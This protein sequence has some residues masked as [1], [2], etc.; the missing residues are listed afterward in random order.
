MYRPKMTNT[1]ARNSKGLT[2][3]RMK[4]TMRGMI[5]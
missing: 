2:R 4:R 1:P 5:F 3:E